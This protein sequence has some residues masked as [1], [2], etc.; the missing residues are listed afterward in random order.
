MDLRDLIERAYEAL[1]V[2]LEGG[3]DIKKKLDYMMK[4]DHIE[5]ASVITARQHK[6]LTA[7]IQISKMFPDTMEALGDYARLHAKWTPS[8]SGTRSEQLVKVMM[9]TDQQLP[10]NITT[11][12]TGNT[13]SIPEGKGNK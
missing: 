5:T 7:M 4:P 1:I 3:K 10:Q 9:T 8:I 2:K 6:A 12:S 11:I 13:P